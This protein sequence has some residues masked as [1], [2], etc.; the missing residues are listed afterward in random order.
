MRSVYHHFFTAGDAWDAHV[1]AVRRGRVDPGAGMYEHIT[2]P[3]NP[4]HVRHES[5]L[6][7]SEGGGSG[8]AGGL[9]PVPMGTPYPVEN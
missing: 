4:P 7:L 2:P 5:R 1:I 9:E 6:V 3:P 8:A